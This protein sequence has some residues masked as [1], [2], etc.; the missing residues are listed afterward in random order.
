MTDRSIHAEFECFSLTEL[1][2]PYP[3]DKCSHVLFCSDKC[4]NEALKTYHRYECEQMSL[5][6]NL[7]IAFLGIR[8]SKRN[9]C[10]KIE[11]AFSLSNI[12]Q[13]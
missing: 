6:N 10:F 5:L 13:N 1:L 7:G 4:R 2:L 3:C 8:K 11:F 9:V 12:D